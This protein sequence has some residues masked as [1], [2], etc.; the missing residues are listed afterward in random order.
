MKLEYQ[1]VVAVFTKKGSFELQLPD[2]TQLEGYVEHMLVVNAS[3]NFCHFHPKQG[4][5]GKFVVSPENEKC[6]L[7]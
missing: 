6:G 2:N 5:L 7:V 3:G 1:E 4:D